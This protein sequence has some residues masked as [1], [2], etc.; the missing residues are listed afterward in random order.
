MRLPRDAYAKL[1][2]PERDDVHEIT[3]DIEPQNFLVEQMRPEYIL[4]SMEK[5]TPQQ[6]LDACTE[7]YQQKKG[8]LECF[9]HAVT[10]GGPCRR[11]YQ[12]SPPFTCDKV[13]GYVNDPAEYSMFHNIE[14]K[15]FVLFPKTRSLI[16]CPD[17]DDCYPEIF[18]EFHYCFIDNGFLLWK[19]DWID[20]VTLVQSLESEWLIVAGKSDEH[21]DK[22]VKLS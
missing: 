16:R 14:R 22:R 20:E 18:Y 2:I 6:I 21:P 3:R 19:S 9:T 12:Y 8:M 13:Y 5:F 17:T 4:Q 10:H 11:C 1:D 7:Y 15:Y